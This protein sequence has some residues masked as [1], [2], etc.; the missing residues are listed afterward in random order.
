[1][2]ACLV[3]T[4]NSSILALHVVHLLTI[5]KHLFS[6]DK[7]TAL[8]VEREGKSKRN[9][10]HQKPGNAIPGFNIISLCGFGRTTSLFHLQNGVPFPPWGMINIY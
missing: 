8:G 9:L 1:M 2:P 5:S 10:G 6:D 7:D 3:S 4:S